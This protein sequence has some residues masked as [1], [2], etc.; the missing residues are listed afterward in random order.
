MK[1]SIGAVFGI[2][3]DQVEE[4]LVRLEHAQT[5]PRKRLL[6]VLAIH[7]D[8]TLRALV[9]AAYA[10]H[11][12]LTPFELSERLARLVRNSSLSLFLV[13]RTHVADQRHA[14]H[15]QLRRLLGYD[16]EHDVVFSAPLLG[17]VFE[18]LIECL[19]RVGSVDLLH[20]CVADYVEFVEQRPELFGMLP[21]VDGRRSILGQID[22][23]AFTHDFAVAANAAS[24]LQQTPEQDAAHEHDC[25]ASQ[26]AFET[27]LRVALALSRIESIVKP[28]H[29]LSAPIY[30]DLTAD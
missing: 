4:L 8:S 11:T 9:A 30:I 27:D 23:P 29:H 26:A 17:T 22:A 13:L 12:H 25:A 3:L 6:R 10:E 5:T 28:T 2:D 20:R 7:G 16:G 24:S 18:A 15:A 1:L 14:E 19:R 21:V